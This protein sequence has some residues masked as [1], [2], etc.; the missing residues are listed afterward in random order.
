MQVGTQNW[1]LLKTFDFGG[2]IFYF[3]EPGTDS[4]ILLKNTPSFVLFCNTLVLIKIF[5]FVRK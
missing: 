1:V 3:V 5:F 4:R 2:M